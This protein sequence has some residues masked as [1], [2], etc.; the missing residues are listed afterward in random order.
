[1]TRL[2]TELSA[3]GIAAAPGPGSVLV[4]PTGALEE[5]DTA[6]TPRCEASPMP[7]LRPDLVVLDRVARFDLAPP[8]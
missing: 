7:H 5:H 8:A 1:V 2:L 6:G 4:L 3:P